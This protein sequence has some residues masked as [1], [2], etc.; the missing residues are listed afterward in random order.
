MEPGQ[1][2]LLSVILLVGSLLV[3]GG[4]FIGLR[5]R[6][7][8][9]GAD[10]DPFASTTADAPPPAP[11]IEA[12]SSKREPMLARL[13]EWQRKLPPDVLLVSRDAASGDWVVEIEGQRY[14]R[15]SDV[16]D[17]KAATKILAAIEGLKLFAGLGPPATPEPNAASPAPA[18][19]APLPP[20]GARRAGMAAYPAPEGSIIAQIEKILQRELTFHADLKDRAI[21]MG[22]T[23]DGSLLI[24]VDDVYYRTPDDIP[25]PNVREVVML[26]VRTWE[27]SS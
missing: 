11:D 20:A 24:E 16:H 8:S 5:S 3:V 27:K 2:L 1:F 18:S 25:D 21:H 4:A 14:R 17:D 15:L 9:K 13:P 6:R 19:S 7:K 23:P 10:S 26:A 12:V 22:A